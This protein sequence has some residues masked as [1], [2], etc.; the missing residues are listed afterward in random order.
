[1]SKKQR[2]QKPTCHART[3]SF[4]YKSISLSEADSTS[5]P[6]RD[7]FINAMNSTNQSIQPNIS[8]HARRLRPSSRG[9]L[10]RTTLKKI[11]AHRIAK[12]MLQQRRNPPVS[13]TRRAN[14]PERP[15]DKSGNCT[16]SS[17]QM[18]TRKM[19]T[20]DFKTPRSLG[21]RR[22]DRSTDEQ[23]PLSETCESLQ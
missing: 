15:Y 7:L 3:N 23:T 4:E 10:G 8:H 21:T 11:R 9:I 14:L 17:W 12:R 5:L 6:L 22:G 20:V 19:R 18:C 2:S 13:D 16:R 1:M